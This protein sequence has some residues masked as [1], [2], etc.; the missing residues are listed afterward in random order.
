M[1]TSGTLSS[2]TAQRCEPPERFYSAL[3][4]EQMLELC[5]FLDS[6]PVLRQN[7]S[8]AWLNR[9]FAD[10]GPCAKHC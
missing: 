3:S 10:A 2:S 9:D 7:Q 1:A 6:I 4:R 8:K 5:D